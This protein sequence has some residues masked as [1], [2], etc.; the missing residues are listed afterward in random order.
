[1]VIFI[2]I[3][4]FRIY[5]QIAGDVD[6]KRSV[7]ATPFPGVQRPRRNSEALLRNCSQPSSET[8]RIKRISGRQQHTNISGTHKACASASSERTNSPSEETRR[9][10]K[11]P[12][13]ARFSGLAVSWPSSHCTRNN[14]IRCQRQLKARRV[15]TVKKGSGRRNAHC[16]R[17]H[18][19]LYAQLVNAEEI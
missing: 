8:K 18:V 13:S 7:P 9:T 19:T 3:F 1:M 14:C 6:G 10:F 11:N 5:Y 12:L 2:F 16:T 17:D 4:D 15:G